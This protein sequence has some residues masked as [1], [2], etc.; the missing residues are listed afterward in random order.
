MVDRVESLAEVKENGFHF[1]AFVAP[2]TQI[3][4]HSQ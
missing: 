2:F 4:H 3:F 1:F